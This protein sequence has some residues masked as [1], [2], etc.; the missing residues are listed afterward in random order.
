V[1][2]TLSRLLPYHG[3]TAPYCLLFRPESPTRNSLQPWAIISHS[4]PGRIT[5]ATT[6]SPRFTIVSPQFHQPVFAFIVFQLPKISADKPN[7]AR[8]EPG[9][10]HN[11]PQT[12]KTRF[13]HSKV[14]RPQLLT[15]LRPRKPY[16]P[17]RARTR[18]PLAYSLVGG[19]PRYNRERRARAS[20]SIG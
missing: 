11:S 17:K 15:L 9:T 5:L 10:H 14:V 7:K 1:A 8:K 19:L 13:P 6:F 3:Q 12:P 4:F 16:F 18:V 20:S 2:R